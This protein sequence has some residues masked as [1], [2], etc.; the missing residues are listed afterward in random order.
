MIS[1][2]IPTYNGER[3]IQAQLESILFQLNDFDEIII[4]DDCSTDNTISIIKELDDKRIKI[5]TNN[6]NKGITYNIEN[7]L[8]QAAG[9]YIF[10][11]DQDDIWTNDKIE[12]TIKYLMNNYLVI[13]DCK[14]VDRNLNILSESYLKISGSRED[15][16]LALLFVTP[17]LG[18]CMAFKKE[19]L[20]KC[21]P[22]PRTNTS[23]DI[24]IG[25]ICAFAYNVKFISD[26]LVYYRRHENNLSRTTEKSPNS[27]YVKLNFRIILLQQLIKRLGIKKL[28]KNIF[29]N[30]FSN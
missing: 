30:K 28:I 10:L 2:C 26:K 23:H 8:Y 11:A 1:V 24:W 19:I 29:N 15:K 7:A 16:I 12:K 20:T 14:V 4:T 25:N 9:D 22:F 27:L 5:F 3:Y 21:L 17:Y 13:S 18:C 6:H